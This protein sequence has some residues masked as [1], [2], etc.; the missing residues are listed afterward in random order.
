MSNFE[1]SNFKKQYESFLI[2]FKFYLNIYLVLIYVYEYFATAC[3][4]GA[5]GSQRMVIESLE[6]EFKDG[7]KPLYVYYE[8]NPG[9]LQ[10]YQ[11]LLTNELP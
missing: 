8:P 9:P 2:A 6:L 1:F 4:S 5:C 3:V 11:M 10:E 7:C